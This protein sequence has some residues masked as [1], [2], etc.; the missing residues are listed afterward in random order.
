[1]DLVK[2]TLL[3]HPDSEYCINIAEY[4]SKWHLNMGSYYPLSVQDSNDSNNHFAQYA[5]INFIYKGMT[6]LNVSDS[7]ELEKCIKENSFDGIRALAKKVVASNQ[8]SKEVLA[9][10]TFLTASRTKVAEGNMIAQMANVFV[11]EVRLASLAETH[12]NIQ[13]K[14]HDRGIEFD[15]KSVVNSKDPK[16]IVRAHGQCISKASDIV[17]KNLCVKAVQ[18]TISI[19]R[20]L[21][22]IE[23]LNNMFKGTSFN[24]CSLVLRN[25]V[26]P[27]VIVI[28][29]KR[30]SRDFDNADFILLVKEYGIDSFEEALKEKSSVLKR[31]DGKLYNLLLLIQKSREYLQRADDFEYIRDDFEKKPDV[32]IASEKKIDYHYVGKIVHE[33][34]SDPKDQKCFFDLNRQKLICKS[35][36]MLEAIMQIQK[37]Q[38]ACNLLIEFCKNV[39]NSFSLSTSIT[40]YEEQCKTHLA[41]KSTKYSIITCLESQYVDYYF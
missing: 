31:E 24:E 26:E 22:K 18:T 27:A 35:P 30:I 3:H 7:S 13:S 36:E 41:A 29:S 28:N 1:M 33:L 34:K 17:T 19:A 2:E 11:S 6:N 16:E 14:L 21:K 20:H 39:L 10:I 4:S 23:C 8:Y 5:T 15:V 9:H 40:K 37:I 25:V 38:S 12:R 32:F